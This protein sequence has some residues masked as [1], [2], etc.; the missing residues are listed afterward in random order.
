MVSEYRDHVISFVV[1]GKVVSVVGRLVAMENCFSSPGDGVGF[2]LD[3]SSLWAFEMKPEIDLPPVGA[4]IAVRT[5]FKLDTG[6]YIKC[7]WFS[8]T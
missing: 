7:W 4:K 2:A 1:I 8:V 5:P 6:H 3:P